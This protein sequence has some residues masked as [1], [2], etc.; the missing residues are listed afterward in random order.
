MIQYIRFNFWL[1]HDVVAL[2]VS[3]SVMCVC[4][5][6]CVC[7]YIPTIFITPNKEKY[8]YNILQKIFTGNIF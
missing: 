2:H 6:V 4:V 1:L 8:S 7:V 3:A 5:C